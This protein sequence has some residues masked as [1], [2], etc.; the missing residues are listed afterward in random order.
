M[1]LFAFS[2]FEILI[3]F[4]ALVRVGCLFMLVPFFSDQTIPAPAKVLLSFTL[5]L[6]MFPLIK[7]GAVNLPASVFQTNAGIISVVLKEALVGLSLGF[8]AKM[9]YESLHFAFAYIGMQMG[10]N[11]AMM[12]DHHTESSTPVVAQF[13]MALA[14]LLFLAIDGHHMIIK[15]LSDS[16]QLVPVGGFIFSKM[17]TNFM[18]DLMSQVFWI[19]VKLSAPMALVIFL[20][21]I[22]FGIIAKA[23]PQIN[24]LVVSFIVNILAG[25]LVL[26]LTMPV[27]GLSVAEIFQ[28]MVLK[29]GLLMKYLV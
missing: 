8:V 19:A 11:M 3:F 28:Q 10:F 9:F 17:L 13:S 26:S 23:V 6:I 15:A 12:Y 2:E 24:V 16:F 20:L 4:S 25:F 14:M 27:F 7:A 29:M 18:M 5:A 22:A 21:N 1:G